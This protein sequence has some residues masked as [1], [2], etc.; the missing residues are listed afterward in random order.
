MP[1]KPAIW[2]GLSRLDI[3]PSTYG[4]NIARNTSILDAHRSLMHSVSHRLNILDP[5]FTDLGIGIRKRDGQWFVTEF[6]PPRSSHRLF[7]SV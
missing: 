1:P 4:E 5:D 7:G 3:H 6:R 2:S